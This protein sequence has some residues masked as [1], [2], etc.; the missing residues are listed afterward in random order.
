M[1]QSAPQWDR[2]PPSSFVCHFLKVLP[3]QKA[4]LKKAAQ[5]LSRSPNQTT[6][7]GNGSQAAADT[8]DAVKHLPP[9][10]SRDSSYLR[11]LRRSSSSCFR[12]SSMHL[13]ASMYSCQEEQR[14]KAKSKQWRQCAN[15]QGRLIG[16]TGRVEP[17]SSS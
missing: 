12:S 9:K 15:T 2:R 17:G 7:F 6:L 16:N 8:P 1:P 4:F 11:T 5:S 3:A 13:L 14:R 10:R